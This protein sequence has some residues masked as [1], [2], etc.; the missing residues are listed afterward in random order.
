MGQKRDLTLTVHKKSTRKIP[1]LEIS[2]SRHDHWT[3]KCSSSQQDHKKQVKKKRQMLTA[4]ELRN[5]VKN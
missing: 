2:K 4:K 3:V 5:K 1:I